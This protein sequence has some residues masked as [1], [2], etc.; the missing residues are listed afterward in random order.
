MATNP[1]RVSVITST[2]NWPSALRLAITTALEQTYQDFE[3]LI[4][5]DNCSET[6]EQTVREFDDSRI[7]WL[8]LETHQG[9]QS[10]VNQIALKQARG[11]LIAYLNHDDLWLS[12]HLENLVAL[13]DASA[14]LTFANS[15]CLVI[16]PPPHL[17]RQILG[18]PFQKGASGKV[19]CNA[20]TSTVMHPRS[21]GHA[22]GGWKNWRETDKVPTLDF[23]QRLRQLDGDFAV[24]AKVTTIKFHSGNRKHSYLHAT[25]DEQSY[26]LAQLRSNPQWLANELAVAGICGS[27]GLPWPALPQ[28]ARPKDAPF[29]WQIEQ[30][31]RM[32]GLPPMIDLKASEPDEDLMQLPPPTP[33]LRRSGNTT[34]FWRPRGQD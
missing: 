24:L 15:L 17:N 26:V 19:G 12:T 23:F 3:Y 22:A 25:A 34:T 14:D 16:S 28:P 29:G 20:M 21:A 33:L 5:G 1:P 6:T 32:R 8:N 13:F 31:R 10:N 30:W 7:R 9:N 18:M 2:Y 11:E 27:L 4:I